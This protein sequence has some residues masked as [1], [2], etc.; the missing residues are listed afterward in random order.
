MDEEMYTAVWYIDELCQVCGGDCG[1]RLCESCREATEWQVRQ[2]M[3]SFTRE[4]VRHIANC[5]DGIY[6][7]DYL[8]RAE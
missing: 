1:G 3:G 5:I 8:R 6:L 4:Q 2:I 7:E